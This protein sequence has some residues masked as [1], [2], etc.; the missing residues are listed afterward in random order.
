MTAKP[1][2][3]KL[4]QRV[5]E[6]ERVSAE[7]REALEVVREKEELFHNVYNTAPLAFVVW[8]LETRVTDWNDKAH[9][10]F[11]WSKEEALGRSFF[12]F[13]IPEKDRT[14]VQHVVHSLV[15]GSLPSES[16]NDNLTKD[17]RIITCQWNNSPL[18]DRQ[19]HVMG[20]ISLALDITERNR[21]EEALRHRG[22]TLGSIL[23][24]APT[25][26]GL[27]KDRVLQRVNDRI[28]EMTGY[29]RRELLGQSSRMLYPSDEEFGYVGREKYR[30]VSAFGTGTVETRWKRKDG[31]LIDV[32]LSSTP[33]DPE[34]LSVGVTFT[35]LDITQRKEAEEALRKAHDDLEK[36]NLDLEKKVEERTAE[37][38]KK[39]RQ[40]AQAEKLAVLGQMANRVAHELRNPLT[41]IG[42]FAK[43]MNDQARDDD[44]NKQY[45]EMIVERVMTMEEKVAEIIKVDLP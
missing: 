35:A 45:L 3:E 32:L 36:L 40:L 42:G 39:S 4:E 23:R 11:G 20:A 28:C 15:Q 44:P 22:A 34:D 25:G 6:L 21:T 26:I 29:D 43:R 33:L 31:Q 16:V 27:V 18:H 24:A 7:S 9:E 5:H 2:Y 38:L 1:T 12:D 41:A 37:L 8:D 17:G 19:G 10:V 14:H 30:K 13:L